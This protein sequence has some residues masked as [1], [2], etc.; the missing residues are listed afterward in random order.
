MGAI[1]K[2]EAKPYPFFIKKLKK[3][4]KNKTLAE[5]KVLAI[6]KALQHFRNFVLGSHV[7]IF[8]D[9]KNLTFDKPW[10]TSRIAI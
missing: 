5:K 1:L 7:D 2:Q 3:A 4:E 10:I 9:N 8:T 6:I